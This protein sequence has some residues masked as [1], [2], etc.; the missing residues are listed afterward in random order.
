[1]EWNMDTLFLLGIWAKES[2]FEHFDECFTMHILKQSVVPISQ[3]D[4]TRL[5]KG[6]KIKYLGKFIYL[7]QCL[8]EECPTKNFRQICFTS[9]YHQI[10]YVCIPSAYLHTRTIYMFEEAPS[11]PGSIGEE[12]ENCISLRYKSAN[13]KMQSMFFLAN[14][15]ITSWIGLHNAKRKVV[16]L[17]TQT[18]SLLPFVF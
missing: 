15:H 11:D 2:N 6:R 8:A 16:R 14:A 5:G 9:Y 3:C 18:Y 4:T 13:L 7:R 12:L 1:M 17:N 10:R